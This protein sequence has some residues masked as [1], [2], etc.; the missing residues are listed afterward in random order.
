[1]HSCLPSPGRRAHWNPDA[2]CSGTLTATAKLSQGEL[3]EAAELLQQIVNMD[4]DF[5][6]ALYSL[7]FV[8]LKQATANQPSLL[9]K[10]ERLLGG[11]G[12]RSVSAR[13]HAVYRQ[14][15]HHPLGTVSTGGLVGVCMPAHATT[16]T[17]HYDISNDFYALWLDKKMIYSCGHFERPDEQAGG[18]P[19]IGPRIAWHFIL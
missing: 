2:T 15:S 18:R 6:P 9:G 12:E 13:L 11:D 8:F 7:G 14:R 17:Y 4:S 10:V 16:I 19:Q 1:V 5:V 3:P